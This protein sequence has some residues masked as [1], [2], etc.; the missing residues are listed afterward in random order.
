MSWDD[1]IQKSYIVEACALNCMV[2]GERAHKLS[3]EFK[4]T[5]DGVPWI[6]LENF[7]HRIAHTYGT[8][9]Y[10]IR[11]LWNTIKVDIPNT[12]EYCRATLN[13][14][15]GRSDVH[16]PNRKSFFKKR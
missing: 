1:F 15:D 16:T 10:D 11:I 13:E 4:H 12:L 7:R 14:Y 6:E 9:V 8:D 3:Y 5:Y 2:M